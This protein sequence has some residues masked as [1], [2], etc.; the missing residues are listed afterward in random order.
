MYCTL[1][2]IDF[3]GRYGTQSAYQNTGN[4]GLASDM[5]WVVASRRGFVLRHPLFRQ[6][7]ATGWTKI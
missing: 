4:H 7:S 3:H 2:W 1:R 6:G 5:L